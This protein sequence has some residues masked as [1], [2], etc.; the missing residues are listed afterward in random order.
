MLDMIL[1]CIY[2]HVNCF[3][4]LKIRWSEIYSFLLFIVI[5]LISR[6][7]YSRLIFYFSADINYR[8]IYLFFFSIVLNVLRG[9]HMFFHFLF[10]LA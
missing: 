4:S 1:K 7:E 3:M 10:S 2:T 6:C 9:S 8:L 5:D